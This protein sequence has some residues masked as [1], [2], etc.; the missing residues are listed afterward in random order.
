MQI[1]MDLDNVVNSGLSLVGELNKASASGEEKVQGD[2]LSNVGEPNRTST[3]V[4]VKG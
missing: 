1:D 3:S 2:G 4:K